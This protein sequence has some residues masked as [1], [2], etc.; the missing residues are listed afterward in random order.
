MKRGLIIFGVVLLVLAAAVGG[1]Y[2]WISRP[3]AIQEFDEPGP[4]MESKQQNSLVLTA[5]LG[6]GIDSALVDVTPERVY[7]AYDAPAKE[8]PIE[9]DIVQ[10]QALFAVADAAPDVDRA[11]LVMYVDGVAMLVWK[12]DL[13]DLRAAGDSA[14]ALAAYFDTIEKT[15]L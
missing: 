15:E 11:V 3:V 13:G 1:A 12:A 8:D 5:L 7:V 4:S 9:R 2:L 6:S 14:D 10:S